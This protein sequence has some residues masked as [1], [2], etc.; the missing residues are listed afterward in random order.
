M[1]LSISRCIGSRL[2]LG[3]LLALLSRVHPLSAQTPVTFDLDSGNPALQLR[4]AL[5]QSI[6]MFQSVGDLKMALLGVTGSLSIQTEATFAAAGFP[7][8]SG[9]P[10]IDGNFLYGSGQANVLEIRFDRPI[11][12][13]AVSFATPDI[14][15]TRDIPTAVSLIPLR[16]TGIDASVSGVT[17]NGTYVD[18]VF[19]AGVLTVDPGSPFC[20]AQILVPP[21]QPLSTPFFL[22]DSIVATP[23]SDPRRLV[24]GIPFPASGGSV[25]GGGLL[26]P[27]DSVALTASPQVG[28]GFS[29]WSENGVV[30]GTN[31]TLAV[32]SATNRWIYAN[33]A[34]ISKIAASASPAVGGTVNGS[35][36]YLGGSVASITAIPSPGYSFSAWTEKGKTVSNNSTYTWT[37]SG[38]RTLVAVFQAGNPNTATVDPALTGTVSGT[39]FFLQGKTVN[40]VATPTFG[41]A[42][43]NWTENNVII[44]TNAILS[45]PASGPRSVVA[46]FVSAPRYFITTLANPAVGG[47]V[48]GS[49]TYTPHDT[50]TLAAVPAPGYVFRNWSAVSGFANEVISTNPVLS[51]IPTTSRTLTAN[52]AMGIA[53]SVVIGIAQNAPGG[54]I[55]GGG[56]FAVGGQVNVSA[57]EAVGWKFEGWFDGNQK[58]TDSKTY[59]FTAKSSQRL[60]GVFDPVLQVSLEA[61]GSIHLLWPA[62]ASVSGF[63]LESSEQLPGSSWSAVTNSPASSQS[64]SEVILNS[65]NMMNLYRLRQP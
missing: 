49:G 20:S 17:T 64:W 48:S 35:G 56:T 16:Y 55:S 21:G 34:P 4:A 3:F 57:V 10:G 58:L 38:N 51:F 32:R 22:V 46:H 1:K 6:P 53:S 39:G 65:P 12:R 13:L 42:F 14:Q 33:F 9:L 26:P 30:L 54:T 44:S 43:V 18:A 63:V 60:L 52:F 50:V 36:D 45:Y 15:G 5:S 2:C 29:G 41:Y 59:L 7:A 24:A 62:P 31:T 37:V 19:A 23:S 40:L 27:G 25:T 8:P 28:Y 47:A 11:S 61:S